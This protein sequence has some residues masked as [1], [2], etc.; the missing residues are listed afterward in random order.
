[1][2]EAGVLIKAI[3]ERIDAGYD[4]ESI[5]KETVA[6][7][8]SEEIFE[9]A[10]TVANTYQDPVMLPTALH[11][12]K[13]G[14]AFMCREWHL[15]LW[16][17][18]PLV[19]V[20][21]VDVVLQETILTL[22]PLTLVTIFSVIALLFY[23]VGLMV[24][25]R[26][27][28]EVETENSYKKAI[29]WTRHNFLSLIFVYIALILIVWGGFVLF[30]VPGVIASIALYFSLYIVAADEGRGEAA[31]TKSREL[32]RGRWWL[33]AGKIIGIAAYNFLVIVLLFMVGALISILFQSYVSETI[34]INIYA[35]GSQ[36]VGALIS[37]ISLYA[38]AE[39]YR[40]LKNRE[41]VENVSVH[42]YRVLAVVGAVFLLVIVAAVSY[43]LYR[44]EEL[45]M[46][47]AINTADSLRQELSYTESSAI[48]F[49]EANNSS[50]SGFC[51]Y[52]VQ[53]QLVSGE[54]QCNDSDTA[55][56]LRVENEGLVFCID[57]TGYNK[58]LGA[59]LEDRTICL[60]L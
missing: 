33:V 11:L 34:F 49:Y 10:Y 2:S 39:L 18:I 51:E 28:M 37:L 38:G 8:H 19:L 50:Y 16:L 23:L 36:A 24:A 26:V 47:T 12:W 58:T 43:I 60:P 55:W 20:T 35:I 9:A 1:M 32:V 15:A 46:F 45:A 52:A 13:D 42:T 44:G 30:L 22:V 57:S 6:A 56:A 29:V 27:T 7:G 31:L 54:V 14:F 40:S 41:S 59:P 21:L 48:A 17:S 53:L 3:K 4:K 25:L 5:K